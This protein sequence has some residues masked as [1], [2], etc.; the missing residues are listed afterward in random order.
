[1]APHVLRM[2]ASTSVSIAPFACKKAPNRDKLETVVDHPIN[3][4]GM[5]RITA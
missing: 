2:L 3:V 1:M 4:D 5:S